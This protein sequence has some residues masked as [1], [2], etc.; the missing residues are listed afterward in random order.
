MSWI[1]K[2]SYVD[3]GGGRNG[4][5]KTFCGAR[6]CVNNCSKNFCLVNL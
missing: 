5:C 6:T 1:V 4:Y 3:P 2:P